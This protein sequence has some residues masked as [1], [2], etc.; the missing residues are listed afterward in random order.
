MEVSLLES[1]LQALYCHA[2]HQHRFAITTYVT[3]QQG[4]KGALPPEYAM[5]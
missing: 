3:A 4:I 2:E 1:H 5:R